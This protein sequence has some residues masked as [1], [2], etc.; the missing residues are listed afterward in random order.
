MKEIPKTLKFMSFGKALMVYL[1]YLVGM[2]GF[3]EIKENLMAV[4]IMTKRFRE[5]KR[6]EMGAFRAVL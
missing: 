5:M 1:A 2:I 6:K 4:P 3:I